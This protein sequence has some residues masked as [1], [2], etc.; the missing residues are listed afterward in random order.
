MADDIPQSKFAERASYVFLCAGPFLAL[1]LVAIRALRIPGLYVV[2][3]LAVFAM[4]ATALWELGG[5][6]IR[7]KDAGFRLVAMAAILLVLPFALIA[8]LWVGLGP[9]WV[10]TE[11]ENQMRYVVL[12]VMAAAVVGGFVTLK[13]ALNIAEER[14]YSTL[15]FA[16][17]MIASP[18]YLVGETLLIAAFSVRVRTGQVSAVFVSL[19][20]FQDVLMFLGGSLI[21]AAG[22]AFA[23]SLGRV[24]WIGRGASRTF[25]VVS[26]VALVCLVMRGLQ[27]PDPAAMSAPWY[28]VPGFIAGIPA[29]PFI[30]PCLLGVAALA[31]YNRSQARL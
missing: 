9:P 18:L 24:K 4:F 16:A 29:V 21:Y 27:F 19:S 3:G 7:S 26:V 25:V 28:T 12:V 14:F 8:L 15:G 30:V 10:A 13:E 1:A 2:I 5:R 20:E 11:P 6:A 31:G 17:V 22:G 23:I